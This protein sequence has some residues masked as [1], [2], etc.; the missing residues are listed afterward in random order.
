MLPGAVLCRV[1]A[2][3]LRVGTF[4]YASAQTDPTLLRRLADHAIA[5]HHPQAADAANHH[6]AL[7]EA[8]SELQAQLI[9]RWMFVGFI[10]GVMNTDTMTISGERINSGPGGF[11]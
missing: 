1:A 9:A 11:T 7:L 8:V 5:R 10:H 6:L 2:S 4:Q 3:H